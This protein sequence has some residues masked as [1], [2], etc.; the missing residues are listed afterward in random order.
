[1]GFVSYTHSAQNMADPYLG[2]YTGKGLPVDAALGKIDSMD[3]NNSY[4]ACVPLWYRL[5]N[6]GFHLSASAGT[7][8]F[9]NHVVSRRTRSD[10]A[11]VRIDGDLTYEKWIEG[12]RLGR[13]FVTNGP[14]VEII[15][16]GTHRTGDT[17]LLAG[18]GKVKIKAKA[19]WQLPLRRAELIQDG[20]VIA[21]KEF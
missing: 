8:C 13:S 21:S 17:V 19:W 4:P 16:D 3:L 12:L 5:L 2:A 10:R 6:C 11:Y 14:F 20:K 18:P 9:M 1:G 15:A 7:D